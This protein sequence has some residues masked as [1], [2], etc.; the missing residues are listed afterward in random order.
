MLSLTAVEVLLRDAEHHIA[1]AE[2]RIVCQLEHLEQVR[3]D[4]ASTAAAEAVLDALR[5]GRDAWDARRSE[6]LGR[7][8]RVA[9]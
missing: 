1:A 6:L 5:R 3:R 8:Y 7:E 9:V 4:G 2:W